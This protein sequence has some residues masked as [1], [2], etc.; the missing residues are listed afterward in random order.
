MMSLGALA[1]ASCQMAELADNSPVEAKYTYVFTADHVDETKAS[2][3][4]KTENGWPVIWSQGDQMGVYNEKGLVGVATL[5]D[6]SAGQNSGT[7]AL[8]TNVELKEGEKLYFSYPY[9]EGAGKNEGKVIAEHKLT[10]SGIGANGCAYAEVEYDGDNT[11]FTLNHLNA[12]LKLNLKSEEF[13]GYELHG[14]TLWAAGSALSGD[15]QVG[16]EVSYVGS[17]DYVKTT[18][19]T[20]VVMGEETHSVFLSTLPCDLTDK[21]IYAIVHMKSVGK[22]PSE[23]VTLPVNISAPEGKSRNLPAGKVSSMTLPTLEK[24]LAPKWYEPVET[25]YIA[26]NG[27]GWCYGPENTILFTEAGQ[28]QTIE[29]KARGNFMKVKEPM[30]IK[31]AY[32]CDMST[33]GQG[34]VLINGQESLN[35]DVVARE[36][37]KKYG[38]DYERKSFKLSGD[39][40]AS[41]TLNQVSNY[42]SANIGHVAALYVCDAN[43][44][45]IW[46]INLWLAVNPL[47]EIQYE[48]G[49]VLD[50]NIG[51]DK[52]VSSYKDWKA[53]GCYFQ[54][55]RPFAQGWDE[56][57]RAVDEGKVANDNDL[58]KSAQNPYKIY[59]SNGEPY[60][61]YW[62]DGD[63]DDRSGDLDDL[64][65][66][67][68]ASDVRTVST[69]GT[70]SI[71]DP[72]PHGYMVVS[73]AILK[74]VEDSNPTVSEVTKNDKT[75]RYITYNGA[76]WGFSGVFECSTNKINKSGNLGDA[77]AY[78]SNSN[79]NG[80]GRMMYLKNGGSMLY[81]GGKAKATPV[82]CMVDTENR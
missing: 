26:A 64:W 54:W 23:T 22:T 76:E 10:D 63:D 46:G 19:S 52:K 33:V 47:N 68:N 25:R 72:C 69:P 41:V 9:R 62:G 42:V 14:V 29:F 44:K 77:L 73:P 40:T 65:G 49:K 58:T 16:D 74:E 13:E 71:Y 36:D 11:R 57:A 55:G 82:R 38:K 81:A 45:A 43:Y 59:Y 31:N 17:G 5:D 24:S 39:Y 15:I 79:V 37:N 61:W 78:W 75:Y 6:A 28:T 56:N 67:P 35:K 50:R 48:N 2:I 27:E 70:K 1:F 18:L 21:T 51:S 30:Y 66:N 60:D 80:E 8:P 53:N 3:G 4:D 32:G 20:P 34:I 7:F 12:Y